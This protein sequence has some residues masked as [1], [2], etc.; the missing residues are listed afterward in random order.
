MGTREFNAAG[1]GT[2]SRSRT[3]PGEDE[4]LPAVSGYANKDN[5]SQPGG[6]LHE[7]SNADL[8]SFPSIALR[9]PNV[10]NF[11]RD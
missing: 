10:H 7:G 8:R 5:N 6:P 1:G 3:P 2:L 9:I 4:I 11:T